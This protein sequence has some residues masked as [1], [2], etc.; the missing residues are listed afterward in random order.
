MAAATDQLT[1]GPLD[2]QPLV[3]S[4]Q[5][6]TKRRVIIKKNFTILFKWTLTHV[7]ITSMATC[8]FFSLLKSFVLNEYR[9]TELQKH[10]AREIQRFL[11]WIYVKLEKAILEEGIFESKVQTVRWSS[12]SNINKDFFGRQQKI[13]N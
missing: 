8:S 13:K 10:R 4:F 3:F 9:N 6:I 12:H 5:S 1:N 2:H 7:K 11:C